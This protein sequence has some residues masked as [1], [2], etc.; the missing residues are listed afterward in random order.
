MATAMAGV[1]G[2]A[3]IMVIKKGV[4]N[5]MAMG[6]EVIVQDISIP[7]TTHNQSMSRP[8][9]T[10]RHS[11]HQAS[12]CFFHLILVGRYHLKRAHVS[13]MD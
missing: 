6:M 5:I 10:I 3:A 1:T 12:V 11:N 13:A 4:A 7:T 2:A 8:Q 9:Y